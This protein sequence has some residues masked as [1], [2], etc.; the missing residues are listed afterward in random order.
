MS[1]TITVQNVSNGQIPNP[2]G[3]IFTA[4]AITYVKRVDLFNADTVTDNIQIWL[5]PSGG[6]LQQWRQLTLAMQ[7]SADLLEEGES[8]ML[9][10]GDI[11]Q[12]LATNNNVVNFQITWALQ[13]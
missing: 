4:T 5:Q 1:V 13:S 11:I 7:E 6:T 12:A 3:T 8:L 2:I 10:A 9:G